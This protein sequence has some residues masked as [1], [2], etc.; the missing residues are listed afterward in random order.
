MGKIGEC[1]LRTHQY[2]AGLGMFVQKLAAGRQ[3]DRRTV[4]TAHAINGN[5]VHDGVKR[6]YRGGTQKPKSP[7]LAISH[8]AS[9]ESEPRQSGFGLG[10]DDFTAAVKAGGADVV[11]QMHFTGGGLDGDAWNNQRI[12]RAVHATLGRGLFVLLN[13]HDGLLNES[14][15]QGRRV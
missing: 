7:T 1:G 12:V 5:R 2:H 6:R 4:V 8:R 9:G 3:G 15:A 11:A 13:C 10:L 14:A